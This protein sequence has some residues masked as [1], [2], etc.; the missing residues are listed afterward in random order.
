MLHLALRTA[1]HRIAALLAVACA[2]FG[3]AALLTGTGVFAESG[4]R[5]SLPA[6]RL[7]G[8]DVIVAAEQSVRAPG[9]VTVPLTER[10]TVPAGL[11]D[12]L[13]TL[14]GVTRA[15]TD[16]GFP[17]AVERTDGALATAVD[18]ATAGH[19]WS[20]V[21]LLAHPRVTGKAPAGAH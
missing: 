1:R 10:G 13:A 17:A 5:S 8:A 6:G 9:D 3:A 11:V 18:P 15:A 4:L 20:S 2:V 19:G 7:A 12:R 16:L 21:H 14:P